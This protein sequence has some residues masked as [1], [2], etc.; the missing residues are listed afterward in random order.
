MIATAKSDLRNS[1][2]N[3]RSLSLKNQTFQERLQALVKSIPSI[4]FTLD[5]APVDTLP[6]MQKIHLFSIIQESLANV[7]KHSQATEMEI[8]ATTTS[9]RIHDNGCG[10]DLSK[11]PYG[12]FGLTG[13]K[14]RCLKIGATLTLQS[15]PG[16]GTT[17]TVHLNS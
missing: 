12:H 3:L 1:I 14:E 7:I 17:I 11:I 16:A 6:E 8:T 5:L 4:R 13:M 15:Q 10:F 2:W 9:L